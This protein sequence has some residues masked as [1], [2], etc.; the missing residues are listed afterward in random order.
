MGK[1][2]LYLRK[3]RDETKGKEDVL[4]NHRAVLVELCEKN[5]WEYEIYQEIGTSDSLEARPK[6]MQ[7]LE[8]VE[9]GLYD[10]V[11]VIEYERLSRGDDMDAAIIKRAFQKAKVT[12][13]TPTQAYDLQDETSEALMGVS[14]IFARMEYR[15]I[16]R[17]L[18][19]GKVAGAKQGKWVQG[20]P[21]FPYMYDAAAK[22]LVVEEAKRPQYLMMKADALAGMSPGD[23]GIKLNRLDVKTNRNGTWQAETVQR[24][25]LNEVHMGILKY[26]PNKSEPPIEGIG[27]HERLKT[28][29]EHARIV[30]LIVARRRI[31]TRSREGSTPLSGLVKCARCGKTQQSVVQR[32]KWVLFAC[33]RRSPTGEKCP[34]SG[35]RGEVVA[36]AIEKAAAIELSLLDQDVEAHRSTTSGTSM[37]DSQRR[38]LSTKQKERKGLVQLKA[39]GHVDMDTFLELKAPLD[40]D[41]Q[42]TETEIVA[43]ERVASSGEMPADERRKKL[44]MLQG[45]FWTDDE[46]WTDKQRHDL[47][48]TLIDRITLISDW[49]RRKV[50]ID[51]FFR[52]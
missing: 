45:D 23:I 2:A 10:G 8:D 21:P 11:L 13:Y 32:G 49:R 12:V 51:V 17:R 3:S 22:R 16:K 36:E 5:D 41:I 40:A 44:R 7:L 6:I 35:T 26:R 37:L 39:Q 33:Q 30:S 24:L 9:D 43:L 25:L 20:N 4:A 38:Y 19:A 29:E 34:N 15:K 28:P 42:R 1:K 48:V 52:K 46:H 27:D 50:E 18:K 47:L 31:A 14:A